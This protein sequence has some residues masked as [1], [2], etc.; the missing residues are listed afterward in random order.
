MKYQRHATINLTILSQSIPIP[1]SQ[2]G[3]RANG[4]F[5]CVSSANL[6]LDGNPA[7][8]RICAKGDDPITDLAQGE[9][10]ISNNWMEECLQFH[11]DDLGKTLTGDYVWC[12]L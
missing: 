5:W 2:K 7:I 8:V 11:V 6:E 1:E 12:A 3:D 9:I 10:L 4:D